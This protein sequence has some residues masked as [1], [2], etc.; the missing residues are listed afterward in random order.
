[1]SH[2]DA[3]SRIVDAAITL[4]TREGVAALSL[5]GIAKESGVSKALV[6]YHH[7]D[8]DALLVAIV[9]RLVMQDVAALRAAADSP[10]ALEAWRGVAGGAEQRAE[11][12]LL[13]ALVQA[14]PMRSTAA[15]LMGPRVQ[16]AAALGQAVLAAGGLR[17]RVG[18]ALLGRVTVQLLDG[19][20]VATVGRDDAA[21]DAELDASALALLGLGA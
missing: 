2:A 8:K 12:A 19:I 9:E 7:S 13:A 20:A 14:S 11:R 15:S 4:G 16:A 10:D 5:Q 18:T 17:S 1:M 3:A 6:L 21:L